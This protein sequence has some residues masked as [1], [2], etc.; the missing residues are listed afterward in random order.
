M[1]TTWYSTC[2]T[3]W[4][5]QSRRMNRIHMWLKGRKIHCSEMTSLNRT[6]TNCVFYAQIECF[7]L[8]WVLSCFSN[9]VD[10]IN[11]LPQ[12]GNLHTNGFTPV[13]NYSE[14]KIVSDTNSCFRSCI[15]FRNVWSQWLHLYTTGSCVSFRSCHLRCR[16]KLYWLLNL[17]LND[18]ESSALLCTTIHNTRKRILL[19][20][21]T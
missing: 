16:F 10:V 2:N 15:F 3:T 21:W 14:P 11:S 6:N 9:W 17:H 5:L 4:F 13:C 19:V 18:N 20:M 8:P 12:P 7:L 1:W